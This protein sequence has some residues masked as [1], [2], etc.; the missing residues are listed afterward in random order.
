[1]TTKLLDKFFLSGILLGTTFLIGCS[2]PASTTSDN[3]SKLLEA[4]TFHAS[5]DKGADADFSK[6]DPILY[7][8]TKVQPNLQI[9]PGLPEEVTLRT[10][11]GKF[12]NYLSFNTPEGV[13]GTRAF[14]KARDNFPFNN[15]GWEGTVSLWLRVTPDEDLRPG[16]TDPI[17]ITPRS[18]LDGCLWVDFHRDI[19]RQFRMGAFPDKEIWNPGNRKINDMPD[20]DKPWIPVVDPPFTRDKWTHVAFTF[21][22]FNLPGKQGVAMLYLNGELRGELR[23][24]EQIYTWDVDASQIRLGVNY[25]GDFDELSC[26]DKALDS[27]SIRTLY[28][29]PNGIG[30]L[31]K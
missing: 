1:M 28:M 15:S 5:F 27:E 19:P 6:G 7:T 24:R 9:Q 17:Q 12:G 23:D 13:Q 11:N 20:S 18:A 25:V 22:K 31:L 30:G 29:L 14:F 4:L 2:G 26:F 16:F 10:N 21:E 8:A 3:D